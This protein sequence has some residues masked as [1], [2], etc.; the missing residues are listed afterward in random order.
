MHLFHIISST[1][2]QY[3]TGSFS[4]SSPDWSVTLCGNSEGNVALTCIN[5]FLLCTRIAYWLMSVSSHV[6]L[7]L[8]VC[9]ASN[10]CP[11]LHATEPHRNPGNLPCTC[12]C[13]SLDHSSW[14]R[15]SLYLILHNIPS[16]VSY[17]FVLPQESSYKFKFKL[18]SIK[19]KNVFRQSR[20]DNRGIVFLQETH[21]IHHSI[22]QKK[23]VYRMKN[24]YFACEKN[25]DGWMILY[26]CLLPPWWKAW[27]Y[28]TRERNNYYWQKI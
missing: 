8:S 12:L 9:S 20:K 11:T 15:L 6:E 22:R 21:F 2:W 25:R 17:T 18:N 16:K 10:V 27:I 5:L 7:L 4:Q 24:I 1:T 13:W 28:D 23:K 26:E 3:S 19:R 14:A